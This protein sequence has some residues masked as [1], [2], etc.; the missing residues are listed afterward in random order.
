MHTIFIIIDPLEV[1]GFMAVLVAGITQS[2]DLMGYVDGYAVD[3]ICHQGKPVEN[4]KLLD[5]SDE[6][7]ISPGRL[8]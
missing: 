2:G 8:W 4:K 5:K 1:G 7:Q 6:E 3:G